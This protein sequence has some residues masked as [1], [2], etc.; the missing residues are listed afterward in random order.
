[1]ALVSLLDDLLDD[2]TGKG[3]LHVA[4]YESSIPSFPVSCKKT[5]LHGLR[6]NLGR[7]FDEACILASDINT[8]VEFSPSCR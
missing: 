3:R 8:V 2:A 6:M 5:E 4:M 7:F 1:M